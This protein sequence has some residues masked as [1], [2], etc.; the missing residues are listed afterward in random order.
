MST[1]LSLYWEPICFLTSVG[2]VYAVIV[3]FEYVYVLVL[4]F[5]EDIPWRHLSHMVLT[6]FLPLLH[7]SLNLDGKVFVN[8]FHLALSPL[9]CLSFF[10][11]P[12]CGYMSY[13]PSTKRGNSFDVG[14]VGY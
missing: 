12:S 13:F 8:S 14:L 6:V 4:L 7:R 5:L 9:K 1:S 11:L 2:L 3:F 10:S